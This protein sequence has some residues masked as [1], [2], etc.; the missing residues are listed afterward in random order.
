MSIR[1]AGIKKQV[2]DNIGMKCSILLK[3]AR[4]K[5]YF[6]NCVLHYAYPEIF[7]VKH[8][9]EKNGKT[10]IM[11]FSYTDLLTKKV[12]I[13]KSREKTDEKGA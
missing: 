9:D 4:K 13:S 2:K 7:S 11:S 6:K 5:L 3:Q 1:L 10:I 12:M 8:T